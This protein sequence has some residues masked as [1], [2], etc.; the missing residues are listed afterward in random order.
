MI[1]DLNEKHIIEQLGAI[2]NE[3]KHLTANMVILKD[4]FEQLVESYKEGKYSE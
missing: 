4:Y 1:D 2:S 3:F